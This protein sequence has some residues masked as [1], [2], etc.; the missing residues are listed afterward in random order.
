MSRIK[1]SLEDE[2]NARVQGAIDGVAPAPAEAKRWQCMAYGC[3]VLAANSHG[4]ALACGFHADIVTERWQAITAGLNRN[5]W[6]V[7]LADRVHSRSWCA[8]TP[9]WPDWAQ[10]ECDEHDAPELAP[11]TVT[12]NVGTSRE[13]ERDERDFPALYAH[14]LRA[15]LRR[16]VTS[17][18]PVTYVRQQRA[19]A[20]IESIREALAHVPVVVD[21]EARRERAA[22]QAE[23]RSTEER[24]GP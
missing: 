5:R 3:P 13:C 10:R 17:N 7:E 22:I 1:R 20:G 24:K 9:N 4:A 2:A 14:R 18:D 23:G 21:E 19:R 11:T 8:D 16:E 12:L 15:W 6:V